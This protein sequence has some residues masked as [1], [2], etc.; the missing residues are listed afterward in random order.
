MLTH[1][2]ENDFFLP[3]PSQCTGCRACTDVCSVRAIEMVADKHGFYYPQINSKCVHCGSCVRICPVCNTPDTAGNE[4][5]AYTGIHKNEEVVEQS[6][7]GGAFSAIVEAW[8]PDLVCGVQWGNHFT[9]VNEMKCGKDY[10]QFSKSKY[11][12]SDTNHVYS[13]AEQAVK[14]G[15]KILFSGTPCQVAAFRNYIGGHDNL[16][17]VDIVCHGAP[18]AKLLQMHLDSLQLKKAADCETQKG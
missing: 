3:E 11:I 4:R 14:A 16:L 17:L 9:A 12:I 10:H 5:V 8:A 18:S 13:R 7:S 15:K 6:A 2:K 1:N